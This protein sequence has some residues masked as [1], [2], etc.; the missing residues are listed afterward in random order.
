VKREQHWWAG[1]ALFLLTT[2]GFAEE[3]DPDPASLDTITVTASPQAAEELHIAQPVRVLRGEELQRRRA[4]SIGETLVNEPGISSTA[5][6]MGASRPVIRG[7]GG[8]RVRILEGGIGS[9]DISNLS[10]DHAVS[11]DAAPASQIEILKGPATLLYGS[12][13]I[14]GVVNVVNNRIPTTLVEQP[15]GEL[16][17]RFD[18]ATEQLAG[19]TSLDAAYGDFGLHFDALKRN[20][21]D[22]AIPGSSAVPSIA[23]TATLANSFTEVENFAGGASYVGTRGY[24]GFS[25]SAYAN[26]YGVPGSNARS[27]A[28]SD[29]SIDL[30]QFRYDL[31]GELREPMPGLSRAKFKLG[32]NDYQHQ[33]RLADG[34]GGSLF[35]NDEYEGRIELSHAPLFDL[36]GVVGVQVQR[37][38]LAA[39]GVEQLTPP[40]TNTAIGVFAVEE[41]DW[42]RWHFEFGARYEHA[43]Y[44]PQNVGLSALSHDVYSLSAGTV[45][46][47]TEDYSAAL[48]VTRALR[49]P[50][51][52]ELFNKGRHEATRSFEIGSTALTPEAANNLDISLRKRSGPW[53]W[54]LNGY[55][56]YIQDFIFGDSSKRI[57]DGRPD[58]IDE[59]V[60]V[61]FKQQDALFYG[62]ELET[63]YQV[64]QDPV[65]GKLD[66]RVFM[67]YVRAQRTDGKNLPRITPLRFGMGL[68]YQ[69][70]AWR[71]D[72][73]LRRVQAQDAVA[74]LETTTP[75]YTLL[76]LGLSY[77]FASHY[78]ESVLSLRGTNLL[79]E[80]IRY[81]TSFLKT[82]APQP[83]RSVSLNLRFSF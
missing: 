17:F 76:N 30:A 14:G 68:D 6:G 82:V 3:H 74:S 11:V 38:D 4:A 80:E 78:G 62:T 10:D 71:A 60:V 24:L 20:T 49:P 35:T 47:Y 25:L 52:E 15:T 5:F 57:G 13:A 22:Y 8:S 72:F 64:L 45:W 39:L 83:G 77:T 46:R 42:E 65:W 29:A 63:G 43:D 73:E 48:S 19:N 53:I 40:V 27:D 56:N 69:R 41:R 55:V 36:R 79:D 23:Q 18:A 28:K 16:G 26:D 1:S 51:V 32:H 12:G 2:S 61:A 37:R 7:L 21:S 50:S 34:A 70:D 59:F 54:Q 67:D 44:D 58:P 33:E 66:V 81:H 9:M 75:G 31:A